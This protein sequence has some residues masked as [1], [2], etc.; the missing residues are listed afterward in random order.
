MAHSRLVTLQ[1]EY[2]VSFL[3]SYEL[4][5]VVQPWAT[6]RSVP[7]C[8]RT[9][10]PA[11]HVVHSCS[12]WFSARCPLGWSGCWS[13]LTARSTSGW[14][15]RHPCRWAPNC[16]PT[17]NAALTRRRRPLTVAPA[18]SLPAAAELR[19]ADRG[20]TDGR[21]VGEDGGTDG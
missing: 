7:R 9:Y 4:W 1:I 21:A 20:A 10:S 6:V 5:Q 3:P 11:R 8:R 18:L 19:N 15:P 17:A 2:D 14:P 16:G 12:E 13:R